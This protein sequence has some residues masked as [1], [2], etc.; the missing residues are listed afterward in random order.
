M[1]IDPSEKRGRKGTPLGRS[2]CT[3]AALRCPSAK[4]RNVVVE[5]GRRRQRLAVRSRPVHDVHQGEEDLPELLVL[6]AV[7]PQLNDW[8]PGRVTLGLH[9]FAIGARQPAQAPQSALAGNRELVGLTTGV[10]NR[11]W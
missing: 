9:A 4:L 8:A 10:A 5:I 1:A 7:R 11:E 6:V 2:F 3:R